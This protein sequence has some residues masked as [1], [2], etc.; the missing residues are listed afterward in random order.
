MTGDYFS[1]I[2][3]GDVNGDQRLDLLVAGNN[4]NK[5]FLNDGVE[6]PFD[7][8]NYSFGTFSNSNTKFEMTTGDFNGDQKLDMAVSHRGSPRQNVVYLNDGD[9]NP[10]DT[11]TSTVG[12]VGIC[13]TA[14]TSG[15]VDD[16]GDLDLALA[17]GATT[18]L[19]AVKRW[20]F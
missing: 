11:I 8:T 17:I 13:T 6:N 4:G 18:A 20:S 3:F 9:G 2:T 5:L 14:L 19:A 1:D 7:G 15:D 10:F 12:P 16:D